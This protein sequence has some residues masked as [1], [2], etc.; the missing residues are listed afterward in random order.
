MLFD[1]VT[2]HL[3]VP[4]ARGFLD[5]IADDKISQKPTGGHLGLLDDTGAKGYLPDLVLVLDLC[6]D[7]RNW[8]GWRTQTGSRCK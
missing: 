8:F 7:G 6:G 2:S 4:N 3:H 5:A 1:P